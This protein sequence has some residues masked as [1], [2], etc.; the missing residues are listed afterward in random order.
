MD[1]VDN[2]LAYLRPYMPQKLSDYHDPKFIEIIKLHDHLLEVKI[3]YLM[4]RPIQYFELNVIV[5]PNDNTNE[6]YKKA[7]SVIGKF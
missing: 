1:E 5:T 3:N 6:N 4:A 7:M 2:F